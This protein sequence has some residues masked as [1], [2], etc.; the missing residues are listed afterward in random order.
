MIGRSLI[1]LAAWVVIAAGLS[2]LA[3]WS[4]S[5]KVLERQESSLALVVE[6][7]RR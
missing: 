7:A 4:T 5:V 6:I 3:R 1:W 2:D